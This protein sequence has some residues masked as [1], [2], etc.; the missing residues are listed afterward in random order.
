M[1]IDIDA[2]HDFVA[3]HARILDR[4]RLSFRS[5]DRDP[6]PVLAAL[7]AYRNPDG[8]YGWG[9]EP[10]LRSPESQ[11]ATAGHAFE[12]FAEI[13]PATAPHAVALCDWLDRVALPDGGL[14]FALPTD[15][16]AGNGPWW[17]SADPSV[18]SLQIT[19]FVTAAALDLAAHDS[20]VA[21]HRW[22]AR[23]T[24][25]CLGAIG[26]IEERPFAYVLEFA[27]RFLDALA[28][29]RPSD[30]ARALKRLAR[31][32][33]RDGTLAVQ[34]GAEG[35]ALRPLDLAPYPGTLS[36]SL[37]SDDV[38]AADLERLAGLQQGDGGW[39]VDYL[40]ISPA[41][42]L[43]WRGYVTVRALDVLRRNGAIS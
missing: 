33:P 43:D 6:A 36:R 35:E 22:L 27:L 4:R 20:A 11:P 30:A 17:A 42:A 7:D 1:N 18:S 13:A 28:D 19:A 3:T 23:S 41:G 12:T 26:G 21:S 5:E 40:K 38:I 32:V 25:Y 29:S 9:L 24:D 39:V 8:G 15:A 34:G 37:L 2:A 16:P 10:D 14:P 31:F